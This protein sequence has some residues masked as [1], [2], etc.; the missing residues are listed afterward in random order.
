MS[1]KS[2]RTKQLLAKALQE[3]L[4][5]TSLSKIT[6]KAV[7]ACA[8]VDRQ[9]FYYHFE[10]MSD[11]VEYAC[12]LQLRLLKESVSTCETVQSLFDE[13]MKGIEHNKKTLSLL[14]SGVG[15]PVM[16]DLFYGDV[17]M[18]LVDYANHLTD[19]HGSR[20]S[21]E[22]FDFTVSYCQY[23]SASIIIDWIQGN[24]AETMSASMLA[25]QLSRSFERQIRGLLG[26]SS[27]G[28]L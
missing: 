8:G 13:V 28:E 9:T 4:E 19:K 23:A 6:V 1:T 18:I 12:L 3:L 27:R 25:K 26:E 5:T 10:T 16:R 14:L 21:H 22:E 15:R 7:A 20:I 2:E 24:T 11:L 17:H